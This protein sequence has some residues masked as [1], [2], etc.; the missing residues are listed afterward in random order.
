MRTHPNRQGI[1]LLFPVLHHIHHSLHMEDLPFWRYLAERQ[2]GP[3]LELGCGTGRVLV[4]LA[5]QGYQAYGL[6]HDAAML[7]YLHLHM[8]E[9][10]RASI[11]VW[12][13]NLAQF[14]LGKSFPLILLP[15]NTLSTLSVQDRNAA[16]NCVYQHLEPGGI[17]AAS[18]P[19]PRLL[20]RMPAN[21]G[22]ELEEILT[23]PPGGEQ[24]RVSSAW[25]R[26]RSEFILT[27]IYERQTGSGQK[28]RLETTVTHRLAPPYEYL[29]AIA[30]A[31]LIVV[32]TFGDFDRSPYTPEAA[33]WI[34]VA[35]KP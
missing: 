29:K 27:W 4:P 26:T 1:T 35:Q 12:Q 33:N 18:I 10:L 30:G 11:H 2:G 19:N 23:I 8:P 3:I 32:E 5:Q 17:F 21:S 7:A 34:V 20:S 28:E 15:C 24:V 31:G 22:E 6:D 25:K 13:A 14:R 16:L 9:K